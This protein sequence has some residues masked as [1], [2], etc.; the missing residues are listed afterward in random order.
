MLM[1]YVTEVEPSVVDTF[2][3]TGPPQVV[4]A[5]N[6]TVVGLV[7][8]LPPAFFEVNIVTL[9]DN[10]RSLMY[11]FL[12][13]GYLYRHVVDKLEMKRG[14]DRALPGSVLQDDLEQDARPGMRM[15]LR[16]ED[17]SGYAQV[18][19]CAGLCSEDL[20]GSAQLRRCAGLC[21][22]D[23]SGCAAAGLSGSAQVRRCAGLCFD[24]LSGSAQVRRCAG[25][26]FDDFSGSAQL[27]GCV[28]VCRASFVGVPASFVP[29]KFTCANQVPLCQPSSPVPTKVNFVPTKLP[30]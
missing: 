11:S 26:C 21:F 22:E 30:V 28:G 15:G 29:T 5:F 14:L 1:K 18:R 2:S 13:T 3:R 16:S 25:L 8:T 9:G 10:L 19:S 27:R 23:L 6:V 4:D 7:G 24:D 12:M 17:L 20:S